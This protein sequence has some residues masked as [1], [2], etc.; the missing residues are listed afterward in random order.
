MDMHFV[1]LLQSLKDNGFYIG[2][3]EDV[4]SRL[5]LHNPGKV[6]S[7][8]SRLPL[9]LIYF[10]AYPDKAAALNREQKLKDFG[11]SYTGLLKR[12]GIK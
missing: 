6:K 9:K 3:T 10:E 4:M 1:Y 11:S 7:T 12:L 8:S 5:N 2:Y